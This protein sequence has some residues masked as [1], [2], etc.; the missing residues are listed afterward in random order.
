MSIELQTIKYEGPNDVLAWKHPIEDFYTGSQL[1]VH[2]SQEALFMGSGEAL[3]LFGPG[4]H[5]LSTDNIPYVA[6]W[7]EK[8]FG[9]GKKPGGETPFH[10]EVYFVN[11]VTVMDILWGT[12]SPLPVE[13]PKFGIIV[14]VRANGQFAIRVED[15][16]KFLTKLVGTTA[17]VGREAVHSYFKGVLMTRIK[18]YISNTMVQGGISFLE[19]HSHLN[20]ISEEI[21]AGIAP[22]FGEYGVEVA[23]FFVNAITVPSDDPGYMKI[24]DALATAK[25][26][27]LLAQGKKKEMELLN[28][29]WQQDRTFGVLD[30]AAQNQGTASNIMGLGLGLGMGAGVGGAVA[31]AARGLAEGMTAPAEKERCAKC[32]AELEPGAR[33]C[34]DCGERVLQPG[35]V[36]CPACGKPTPQGKFCMECG[37]SLAN[38]CRSCGATLLSGA[39]FCPECGA[40]AQEG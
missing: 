9:I 29:T 13:D 17:G 3:D 11:R 27:E 16:R 36:S 21:R 35:T 28:Y 7:Y 32:G 18:D 25:E 39:K 26:R 24:R 30:Q 12:P 34:P 6:K 33:F 38:A 37:A 15:S 31:G 23:N 40:K 8:L 22:V 1:I 10:C 19:V 5:T 20:R 14:P 2:E 4:R